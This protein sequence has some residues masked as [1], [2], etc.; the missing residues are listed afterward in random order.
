MTPHFEEKKRKKENPS[1]NQKEMTLF[2]I[3]SRPFKV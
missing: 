3:T 1:K 2:D